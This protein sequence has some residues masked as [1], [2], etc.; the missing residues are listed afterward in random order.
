[1]M[2]GN[3]SLFLSCRAI[4][5]AC[6]LALASAQG[7]FGAELSDQL[8]ATLAGKANKDFVSVLVF[9]RQQLDVSAVQASY[10]LNR[11]S[12]QASHKL[13]VDELRGFA[14]SGQ[15]GI[16][17]ALDDGKSRGEVRS[18]ESYWITNALQIEATKAAIETL[19]NRSDIEVVIEDLPMQSLYSP[20]NN[21]SA[22]A[23][24]GLGAAD[25]LRM[26]GAD[27]M[28][29]LG[30]TGAGSL[31]ASFD[32]GV[33]GSHPALRSSY[34][35]NHGYSPKECWFD[36]VYNQTYPHWDS[37]LGDTGK[38]GTETMGVMVGKNSAV[39][40]TVGVAFG[41]EWISAMVLDIVG[42]NYLEAFQW[43]ADPD[44]DPNTIEDV[45]DVL[46][47]SWGF[48]Q[49]NIDCSDI[50]WRPIDNL[51]ALGTVV[52]FA[53]GNEGSRPYSLRNPANRA[54]TIYNSFA[55]G[56]S[57]VASDTAWT[58]SSRGPSD[59]DSVSIKPQVVAPGFHVRTISPDSTAPDVI[60]DGTSFAAPHVAGAVALLRQY[61]P[62]ASVDTIKW[63][64]MMSAVDRGAPGP[65]NTYGW[66]RI[67]VRNAMRLMPPN[68]QINIYV[69]SV[70]HDSIHA[71]DAVDVVV[72]LKNSGV[73]ATAVVGQLANP[74]AGITVLSGTAD[75]GNI[76]LNGSSSNSVPYRL[77]FNP[78]IPEG[79]QL[80]VELH[81][82]AGVYQEIIRLHF[83]VGTALVKS[84]YTH[85]TDSC[86]FTISNY[87]IY[88]LA[89]E[90]ILNRGGAGF[91]NPVSG[92]NY[93]HQ[94]GLMIGTDSNHVSDGV[95]NM[96]WTVD[97]DFAVAPGGNL[98]QHTGGALGDVETFSR[99][100]DSRAGNPLGIQVE[101]RTASYASPGDANYVIMEYVITNTSPATISGMRVGLLC[102]WDFPTGGGYD[103][104]GF[105]RA[106]GLGYM[107]YFNNLEFRG[108]AVLNDEGVSTFFAIPNGGYLY[109]GV[110]EAEKYLFLSHGLE[111]TASSSNLDQSYSIAT[112][113]F[114][115]APGQSDTVAFAMIGGSSV[116]SL[117]A[118]A[119]AA[120]TQYEKTPVEDDN[121]VVL[122][123]AYRLE[124]NFPNPFNPVT[125]INYSLPRPGKVTITVFNLLGQRIATLLEGEQAA[126]N[127]SVQWDGTT[128]G[129]V[130]VASG[131]YF[132]RL[133]SDSFSEIKKMILLK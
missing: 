56:A 26:I 108:T 31:V 69:Y 11:S 106:A 73:G 118:S 45:P 54:T 10:K 3:L 115:L 91:V 68:N 24:E 87:G 97:E 85:A 37:R 29:A 101:Q 15:T 128:Q 109:D 65:D 67:N 113:P 112:G 25:G 53:C 36:P 13:L 70:E 2:K 74:D 126:G 28:W 63:A 43:V 35:G 71:G 110:S 75:F 50:F 20:S 80:V 44:G 42:A 33:N 90:S 77:R 27:S 125:E 116:A 60:V 41:A 102:D 89:A 103:R 83:P 122:P 132:Y 14:T 58:R 120:R 16:L 64:L 79:A 22:L 78:S 124:Q 123:A 55:V 12:R 19:R 49:S 66:G 117:V 111:D 40:D 107:W 23:I 127:H 94:C 129:G 21:A 7:V 46:N 133:K 88:G 8:A 121:A 95:M 86:Q 72:T 84:S 76:P 9:M 48:E 38:H 30:Y 6:L 51:E 59:C 104:S 57:V 17:Q 39:G 98:V 81:V 92:T 99:F 130:P 32:S 52:V 105:V 114:N 5:L 1:M 119:N 100:N 62:N 82:Q 61:N 18:Y 34:R 4:A 96:I 47:N 93:L 131:V